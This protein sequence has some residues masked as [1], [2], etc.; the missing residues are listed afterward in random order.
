[1]A[2]MRMDSLAAESQPSRS[3]RGIRLRDARISCI[4]Q[5]R[6]KRSALLHLGENVVGGAVENPPQGTDACRR[7][8]LADQIEYRGSIHDGS[9]IQESN[10]AQAGQSGELAEMRCH[11]PLVRRDDVQA[12]AERLP[13]IGGGRFSAEIQDA[14]FKENIGAA[15]ANEIGMGIAGR[16]IVKMI[17]VGVMLP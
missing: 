11:R 12:R 14:H 9:F 3:R 13:N 8:R 16:S 4:V 17:E 7:Q 5:R 2:W 6:L 10:A 15:L 1:M